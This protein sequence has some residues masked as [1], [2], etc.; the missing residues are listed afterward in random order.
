MP[1]VTIPEKKNIAGLL[2]D[3]IWKD[4]IFRILSDV[5]LGRFIGCLLKY[6]A[7]VQKECP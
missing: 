3:F 2:N 4:L 1:A 5:T 7:V 6:I